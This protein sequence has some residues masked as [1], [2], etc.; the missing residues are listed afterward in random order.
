[1]FLY[2][3]LFIP[4]MNAKHIATKLINTNFK[5]NSEVTSYFKNPNMYYKYLNLI[6]ATDIIFDPKLSG[7]VTYPLK[8]TYYN[9]PNINFFPYKLPKTK[10][11]QLWNC[12]GITYTGTIITDFV[13]IKLIIKPQINKNNNIKL[14]VQSELEKKKFYIPNSIVEMVLSDFEKIFNK[15][16]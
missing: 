6:E 2:I 5:D 11:I 15:V 7:K 13:R 3:L 14:F 9:Y 10:I 1:M 8:I 16:N 12:N 4:L